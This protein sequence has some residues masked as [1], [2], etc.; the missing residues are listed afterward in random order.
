ML[1]E[2]DSFVNNRA[3]R[4]VCIRA[5]RARDDAGIVLRILSRT[6]QSLQSAV[7]EPG[8]LGAERACAAPPADTAGAAIFSRARLV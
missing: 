3:R 8:G 4:T 7:D 1:S 2:V 6:G 5:R